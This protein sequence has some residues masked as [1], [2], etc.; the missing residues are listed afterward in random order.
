MKTIEIFIYRFTI[1]YKLTLTNYII[2]NS[3]LL[4]FSETL[5]R[6]SAVTNDTDIS[7]KYNNVMNTMEAGEGDQTNANNCNSNGLCSIV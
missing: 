1:K 7:S 6:I 5:N 4:L 2:P 3:V